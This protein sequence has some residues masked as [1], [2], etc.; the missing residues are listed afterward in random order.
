M[1]NRNVTITLPEEVLR[2]PR[3]MAA[4]RGVSLSKL[5]A[6]LIGTPSEGIEAE[7]RR[8]KKRSLAAMKR[9]IRLGIARRPSWTRSEL[10]ER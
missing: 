5:F 7:F 9:G 3:S 8:A 2:V 10:H 1:T 6:D 4:E